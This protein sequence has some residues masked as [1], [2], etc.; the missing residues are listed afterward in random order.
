MN[1][2]KLSMILLQVIDNFLNN[3]EFIE[4]INE[5]IIKA[6]NNFAKE[7]INRQGS[8]IIEILSQDNYDMDISLTNYH[9]IIILLF[10]SI[11]EN[12]N[13]DIILKLLTS[14]WNLLL[15]PRVNNIL[16]NN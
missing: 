2:Y 12:G 1:L 5:E 10:I 6:S 11:I 13:S 16:I 7:I 15:P 14:N 9:K 3:I 4:E 8:N